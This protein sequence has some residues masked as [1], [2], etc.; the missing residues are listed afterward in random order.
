MREETEAEFLDFI[1][2]ERMALYFRRHT[3]EHPVTAQ[4]RMQIEKVIDD[5][6]RI[7]SLLDDE[8]QNILNN[9]VD[10]MTGNMAQENE[11]YYRGGFQDGILL[12]QLVKRY[13]KQKK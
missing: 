1:L 10:A 7:L 8:Q 4:E 6:D 11:I 9:C 3:K 13:K 2:N 5:Y 12:D